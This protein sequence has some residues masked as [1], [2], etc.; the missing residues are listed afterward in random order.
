MGLNKCFYWFSTKFF[1]TVS[2]CLIYTHSNQTTWKE[3]LSIKPYR[4]KVLGNGRS[5]Y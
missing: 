3:S 1:D 4:N 2:I 5:K